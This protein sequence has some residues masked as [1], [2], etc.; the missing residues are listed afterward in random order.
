MISKIKKLKNRLQKSKDGSALASNFGYLMLL[1]IAGYVFPLITIPYLARVIGVEGFGKIAF[2]A[3]VVVWFQTITDWGFNYTA[4]RDVAQ[5]R[6]NPNRVSEIF[7]NVLWSKI[8]LM[9]C[10]FFLLMGLI[11]TIPYL[12]ENQA[13]LLIT[14]LMVPGNIFFPDWFFQAMER[15]KYITIFNLISKILFTLLV[16]I[17]IKEKS[18]FI[19]QPLFISLGSVVSGIFAMY[20]IIV[21]WKVKLIRP[22]RSSVFNTIKNS[23]D[24][25]I[26]NIV[27]NFYYGFS[28]ILLS[29]WGGNASVGLLD[30]GRRFLSISEKFLQIV[31]RVFFP[32]LSRRSDKHNTYVKI[33]FSIA[34]LF[35]LVLFLAAPILIKLFYTPEFYPAVIALQ[36]SSFS[37]LF[38]SLRNIYGINYLIVRG[39]EKE[40]R[41]IML[42]TSFIGFTLSFPLIYFFDFIG[43]AI[44]AILV[45]G[46]QGL[47]MMYK[48]KKIEKQS[49]VLT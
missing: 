30:A 6:D 1:Q 10:S 15:M 7:S 47:S 44:T 12:R 16:F 33:N 9:F 24:V 5:N 41:N 35:F 40:A 43:A 23:T 2:A 19:L 49:I 29:F 42:V 18:D 21:K 11:I 45:H 8:L 46:I 25:F 13:I 37:I 38:L 27:P 26:N 17:F 14:F 20:I 34:A 31:S 28:T 22:N 4:T 36:I 32:F 39:Y 48:A 3:A